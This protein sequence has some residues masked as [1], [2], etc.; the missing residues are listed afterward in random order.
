MAKTAQIMPYSGFNKALKKWGTGNKASLT[1]DLK[2]QKEVDGNAQKNKQFQDVVGGLQDFRTYL[3]IKPVSAFVTVLHSPMKFVATSKA[4]QHLL[5]RFV[6][7]VGDRTAMKDP[8]PI[9]LPQQKTWKWETKT[10]SSD[11]MA[12]K[13]YYTVDHTHRGRLW[14]PDQADAHEWMP[15]KVPLLLAIPLL[16]FKVIREEGSR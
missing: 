7:F 12:L 6:G 8:T 4:T 2:W 14:I 11:G 3:L 1:W 5:G 15:V 10:T 9:V 16:L 13:V